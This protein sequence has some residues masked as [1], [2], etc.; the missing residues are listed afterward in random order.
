MF[1]AKEVGKTELGN[2]YIIL[3]DAP[4][5]FH[6]SVDVDNIIRYDHIENPQS[7]EEILYKIN[8]LEKEGL[9]K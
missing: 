7:K 1:Q 6:V 5:S 9:D 4:N 2:K 3:Q 8:L